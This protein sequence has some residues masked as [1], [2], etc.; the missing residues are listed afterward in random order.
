[1]QKPIDDNKTYQDLGTCKNLQVCNC[2]TE[3][4]SAD[5]KLLGADG[6]KEL[7]GISEWS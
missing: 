7:L 3:L 4:Y 6:G 2:L 1:V 5:S